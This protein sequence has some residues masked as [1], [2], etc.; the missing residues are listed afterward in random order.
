MVGAIYV[1]DL[2]TSLSSSPDAAPASLGYGCAAIGLVLI[3]LGVHGG[4]GTPSWKS[5][6]LVLV[7]LGSVAGTG[8]AVARMGFHEQSAQLNLL[9]HQIAGRSTNGPWL[10]QS[11]TVTR[12]IE[13]RRARALALSERTAIEARQSELMQ[14]Y[15][16]LQKART[17][18]N[19]K[20][21]AAVDAFNVRAAAYAAET[22]SL[23]ERLASLQPLLAEAPIAKN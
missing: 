10:I 7:L 20:D 22:K 21:A 16:E 14:V 23:K 13:A 1:V 3:C 9:A 12:K 15:L 8:F 4:F 18:L 5:A 11:P 6:F 17:I 2:L 19:V